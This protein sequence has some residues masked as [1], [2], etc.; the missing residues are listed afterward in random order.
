MS[1]AAQVVS[2]EDFAA[3]RE[4]VLRVRSVFNELPR[5][6]QQ[7]AAYDCRIAPARVSGVL[8]GRYYDIPALE[9]LER[10]TT[11]N[12]LWPRIKATD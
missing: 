12:D 4:R 10:W 8:N 7:T 1:A 6:S 9:A 11:E 3:F 5:G 2:V